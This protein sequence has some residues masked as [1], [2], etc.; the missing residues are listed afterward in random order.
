M[1]R[2]RPWPETEPWFTEEETLVM[3]TRFEVIS[4][5]DGHGYDFPGA[6]DDVRALNPDITVLSYWEAM[7]VQAVGSRM[8]AV[9][10]EE[11]VFIHSADPASLVAVAHE[12]HTVLWFVQDARGRRQHQYHDPPGVSEY[13][14]EVASSADGPFSLV[15]DPIPD[16]G[17]DFYRFEDDVVDPNRVYRVRSRL[18]SGEVVDYS[19]TISVDPDAPATIAAARMFSDG[20]MTALCY[21]DCPANPAGLRVDIDLDNDH[22]YS[23]GESFAFDVAEPYEDGSMLYTGTATSPIVAGFRKLD[24]MKRGTPPPRR[25]VRTRQRQIVD[26]T[27]QP[28]STGLCGHRIVKVDSPEVCAPLS[29]SYQTGLYNNRVQMRLHGSYLV[30]PNHPTWMALVTQRLA[31]ALAAGYDGLRLDTAL[32]TLE[33]HWSATGLPPDW[34]GEEDPR[35][36]D[37][38]DELLATL[39]AHEPNAILTIN[40]F[41]S[42][43]D[44]NSFY[45][46]LNHVDGGDFEFFGIGQPFPSEGHD[47]LWNT[48]AAVEAIWQTRAQGRWA[49]AVAGAA[50]DNVIGRLKSFAVYLLVAD[51]GVFFYNEI[52]F[53]C[54]D[55]VYLPEWDVP[56]G[57]PVRSV[58]GWEDLLDPRG[59]LLLSREF[60]NGWVFFNPDASRDTLDFDPPMYRLSVTGGLSTLLGGDGVAHYTPVDT[61]T[62]D[63]GDEAIL[64]I[65]VPGD[66]G[67]DLDQ[68]DDMDLSD[69][70][71]LLATHGTACE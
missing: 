42:V 70:A 5:L 6:I 15:G 19:W 25:V 47:L 2:Q 37:A 11:D 45:Q 44:P 1:N 14:V 40:G 33:L 66:L 17:P 27:P 51:E 31:D 58:D 38:M 28:E 4:G 7:G 35:I 54:Q 10:L 60:E 36:A 39:A 3:A 71:T 59:D 65:D 52:G 26:T 13:L 46:Y 12:G 21:G 30:W 41:F 48:A 8:A 29:G 64:V 55:V 53:A 61:I 23:V 9:D 69:F 56:L 57:P 67:R 49:V 34:A 62:L 43:R 20:S 16:L 18:F 50:V 68:D 22:V 24:I 32:D 63:H